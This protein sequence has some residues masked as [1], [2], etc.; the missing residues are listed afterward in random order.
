MKRFM[1]IAL[2]L[3]FS[4]VLVGCGNVEITLDTPQNVSITDGVVSWDAVTGAESYNVIVGT[5]SYA[6]TEPTYDLNTL[7]LAA[8]TYEIHIV[9]VA[10]TNIS[11]PSTTVNFV[12]GAVTVDVPQN[13]AINNGVVTWSAVT[14][15]TSYVV[16]IDETTQTVTTTTIN[17]TTLSLA[18]GNHTIYV[19]AMIG[20]D[21]SAASTSVTYF[22]GGTT[23]AAPTNV[24]NTDGTLT[25]SAVT[26]AASYDVY[27]DSVAHNV[28]VTTFDLNALGLEAGTYDVFVV[29][30]AGTDLSPASATVTYTVAAANLDSL[31]ALALESVNPLYEPDMVA[32]DFDTDSEYI[33]YVTT[34]SLVHAYCIAVVDLGMTQTQALLMFGHI[35]STP[36]RMGNIT[37]VTGLMAEVDSYAQFGLDT[38]DIAT[39]LYQLGNAAAESHVIDLGYKIADKQSEIAQL[40]TELAALQITANADLATL[41]TSLMAYATPTEIAQLQY[42]FSGQYEDSY[43]VMNALYQMAND[44]MYNYGMIYDPW[45][46]HTGDE[47]IMMF[48]NILESIRID[49]NYTLLENIMNFNFSSFQN[50]LYK[51]EDIHWQT[52]DLNRYQNELTLMNQI[53]TYFGE[54]QTLLVDAISGV[55]DYL[56]LVYNTVPASMV[57]HL[58]DLITNGDLTIEE[59]FALKDEVVN[60]LQTT[61]PSAADFASVYTTIFTV[62]DAFGYVDSTTYLPYVS[63]FGGLSHAELDLMLTFAGYVTQADIEE[64]MTLAEAVVIPGDWVDD[65]YGGQYYTGDSVD[66]A[67][68]IDFAYYVGNYINTFIADNQT[69]VDALTTIIGGPETEQLI[70]L[71]ATAIKA[72]L[73]MQ[74]DPDQYALVSMAIDELLAKYDD[75]VAIGELIGAV[76]SGVIDEFLSTNGQA[77]L[78]HLQDLILN[79]SGDLTDPTFV[80]D[81]QT[82]LGGLLNY[83]DVFTDNIDQ[84]TIQ[85][86][87]NLAVIPLKV[88]VLEEGIMTETQFDTLANAA[89]PVLA[90]FLALDVT[91]AG[92]IDAQTIVDIVTMANDMIIPGEWVTDEFNNTYYTGDSVDVPAAVDFVVYILGY[93]DSFVTDNQTQIDDLGALFTDGT[94]E[95]LITTFTDTFLA[96]MEPQMDPDQYAMVSM[97]IEEALA[98]YDNYIAA[99]NLIGQMGS[100]VADEFL[101]SSGQ[102]ILDIYNLMPTTPDATDP[103]FVGGVEAIFTQALAYHDAVANYLTLANVQTLLKLVR[104][105]LIVQMDMSGSMTPAE[106][107]LFFNA[108]LIPVSTV[109]VNVISLEQDLLANIDALNVSTMMFDSNWNITGDT[110]LMAVAVTALDMTLTFTNKALFFTTLNLIGDSIL[111]NADVMTLMG[112]ASTTEV[113][114]MISSLTTQFN[115]LFTAIHAAAVLDFTAMDQAA[116][117]QLTAVFQTQITLGT[118]TP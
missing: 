70:N 12:V 56:T 36:L 71:F 49:E 65:G 51:Y 77:V 94:I 48:Y 59:Y 118:P 60:V 20:T 86:F 3:I 44:F 1:R 63:Y 87:L 4:F 107:D 11:L 80:A 68:A 84:A 93:I 7:G 101:T 113:D 75:V 2:L 26:G 111:K 43:Y 10:G 16:H 73:E 106:T 42:F 114:D 32:A 18:Q 74:M 67:G 76:G 17:L 24:V 110:A 61:L 79:G 47:Y 15:A 29:A 27:V 112:T 90:Q 9:A 38:T 50:V 104:V 28:T 53:Q 96:I 81:V 100:T 58:D 34:S 103:V 52:E 31:Y 66:L 13:V 5:N 116:I 46:L 102:I 97:I 99:I 82:V 88:K 14:G 69:K 85:S 115:D 41:L 30:K 6:V 91:F 78:D 39:I 108:L 92:S 37:D 54:Q 25:W 89:I 83:R 72:E 55:V 33:D 109:I 8:G 57:T 21:A 35:A 105:P 64:G 19:V 23:L 98:D 40:Q 62:A 45:Y 22:V 95:A 117:D